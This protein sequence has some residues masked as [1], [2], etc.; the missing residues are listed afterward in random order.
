VGESERLQKLVQEIIRGSELP[1]TLLAKDA[2]ISRAA[3]EAWLS[4]N[5]NP[6][7]Q[8]AEQ[9]AAGLERRATRLQYLA[10]RLR[11]GLQPDR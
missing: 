1:R 10:F 11:N 8:S 3:I 4:G 5:R 9:L 6:T 7:S 2:E